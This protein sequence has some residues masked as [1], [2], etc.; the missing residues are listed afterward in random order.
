MKYSISHGTYKGAL[1]KD[2]VTLGCMIR[3]EVLC[4][5]GCAA[6]EVKNGERV[7]QA[8][9]HCCKRVINLEP[10]KPANDIPKR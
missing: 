6:F 1:L 7:D 3:C 5:V 9:L 10:E 2:G 8:I 4:G